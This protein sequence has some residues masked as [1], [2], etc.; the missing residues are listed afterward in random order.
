M[1][2][3]TVKKDQAKRSADTSRRWRADGAWSN[4]VCCFLYHLYI[5]VC[6]C[7]YLY[8]PVCTWNN[9]NMRIFEIQVFALSLYVS[10]WWGTIDSVC[11]LR[12]I[13]AHGTVSAGTSL[14]MQDLA[15]WDWLSHW[16]PPASESRRAAARLSVACRAC[17]PSMVASAGGTDRD[18]ARTQFPRNWV[19]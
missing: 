15:H 17:W 7:T 6:T 16:Q 1:R 12:P 14:I 13:T 19:Q 18:L 11:Q 3:K 2:K 10:L 4:E 5:P 9:L 8:V